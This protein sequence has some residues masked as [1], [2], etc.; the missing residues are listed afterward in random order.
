MNKLVVVAGGAGYIG[1]HTVIKLCELGY[2]PIIIDNFS[3]SHKKTVDIVK[4]I[5]KK[6]IDCFDI[7]CS[8]YQ[9]L[10][11]C[12][13]KYKHIDAIFHF[14]DLKSIDESFLNKNSYYENNVLS[15]LSLLNIS[16]DLSIKNF[17][18]SSSCTVYG[19][20]NSPMSEDLS[21]VKPES[22]YGHTKQIAENIINLFYSENKDHSYVVLRYF[23]PIGAYKT[24][25]IGEFS[26]KPNNNV[27]N[28]IFKAFFDKKEFV[29][30]G[31]DYKTIDGTPVRDYI[32]VMDVANSHIKCLEYITKKKGICDY[33]IGTGNGVSVLQLLELFNKTLD[34]SIKYRFG[35]RR[36]GDA[37]ELYAN[38]AKI[39]AEVGWKTEYNVEEALKHT[40][41]WE[42]NK[43]N[44]I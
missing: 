3:N 22:P 35:D 33:N 5:T 34:V 2:E 39:Y 1:S 6:D 18:Y 24:G 23:N 38:C 8:N 4:N 27:M 15:L 12:L 44:I 40:L 14:A 20:Q 30:N 36:R 29:I 17:I 11:D 43:K 13:S 7:N 26:L 9:E 10:K 19:N 42:M 21:F 28:S 37:P 25:E 16:K 41:S 31:S 32:H